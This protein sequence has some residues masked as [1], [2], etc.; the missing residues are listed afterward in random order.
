MM[1][2]ILHTGP[3][4]AGTTTIT[5]ATAVAFADS[6]RSVLV[7][8]VEDTDELLHMVRA[9]A[10][11]RPGPARTESSDMSGAPDLTSTS[12]GS[13]TVLPSAFAHPSASWG[14]S[15]EALLSVLGRA[16]FDPALAEEAPFLPGMG[17]VRALLMLLDTFR[18]HGADIVVVDLGPIR[19]AADLLGLTSRLIWTLRRVVEGPTDA[20]AVFRPLAR[21]TGATPLLAARFV[22]G[23]LARL[24][25]LDGI[26]RGEQTR[27]RLVLCPRPA[28]QRQVARRVSALALAGL[29]VDAVVQNRSRR[30][31]EGTG[32]NERNPGEEWGL[33]P[34][35]ER[36]SLPATRVEPLNVGGLRR[37]VRGQA[38]S[39]T[40][41]DR[42]L[43]TLAPRVATVDSAWVMRIRTGQGPG[44]DV[45]V[46]RRGDDV[47]LT[48]SGQ[49]LLLPLWGALR[50]CRIAGATIDGDDLV[51][52][53]RPEGW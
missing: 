51:L 13:V 10:R 47:L 34:E 8:A 9:G 46:H 29:R 19:A 11:V 33:L 1:Q 18:R 49:R 43:V 5:A 38:D 16:G 30:P 45:Q 53:F 7:G 31:G 28:G 52:T 12:G 32:R 50:R 22:A 35:V 36:I 20:A 41:L 37:L 21:L 3:G 14:R 17:Q 40:D 24:E 48:V 6:G 2:V 15:Q 44:V 27:L 39:L 23:T 4:G 26:L 42:S 25:T